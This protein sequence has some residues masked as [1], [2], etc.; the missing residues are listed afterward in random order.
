MAAPTASAAANGASSPR[1]FLVNAATAL[2]KIERSAFA[3]ASLLS[4][5][6]NLRKGRFS[7]KI[8]RANASPPAAGPSTISSIKPCFKASEA[9]IGSPPTIIL[10]ASSGPTARGAMD[11]SH[12]R[13][14]R[15]LDRVEHVVQTRRNRRL[16][17]LGDVGAGN[18][19][20]SRAGQDDRLHF[21]IGNRT[22][23]TVHDAATHGG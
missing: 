21:G 20:A 11:R 19:S 1:A 6:R 10:T 15:T 4:S 18:E 2:V 5:S 7:A 23:E 9:E 3:A 8:F 17:E 13:F 14:R 12:D 22:R 16:A